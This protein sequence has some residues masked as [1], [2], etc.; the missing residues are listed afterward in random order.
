MNLHKNTIKIN[1]IGVDN[2]DYEPIDFTIIDCPKCVVGKIKK[3]E[4]SWIGKCPVCPAVYY[5]FWKPYPSQRVLK[6]LLNM[7]RTKPIWIYNIGAMN[8]GKT[9]VDMSEAVDFAMQNPGTTQGFLANDFKMLQRVIPESLD[10]FIH[11]DWLAKK[12]GV[13]RQSLTNGYIFEN[14]SKFIFMPSDDENKIKSIN[15]SRWILIEGEKIHP[16]LV[17][18]LSARLRQD[19]GVVYERDENGKY[20][21]ELVINKKGQTRIRKKIKQSFYA[22]VVEANPDAASYVF[23]DGL[24]VAKKVYHTQSVQGFKDYENLK[25]SDNDYKYAIITATPDNPYL[26]E[27]FIEEKLAT[28]TEDERRQNLYGEFVAGDT[29]VYPEFFDNVIAPYEL[30][31]DW[32][33]WV[34]LDMGVGKDPTALL[35]KTYDPYEKWYVYHI[36]KRFDKANLTE[37][38]KYL[39]EIKRKWN[40]QDIFIDPS[41]KQ[42]RQLTRNTSTLIELS[43][44][45]GMEIIPSKNAIED[46]I[47]LVAGRMRDKTIKF[48]SSCE[49][50]YAE[51]QKYRYE[52]KLGEMK[53]KPTEKFNHFMDSMRYM[54]QGTRS[55]NI[56]GIISLYEREQDLKH[57]QP[58]L[59]KAKMHHAF[60]QNVEEV[61]TND[62]G[63]IEYFDTESYEYED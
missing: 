45:V 56:H 28:W 3:P 8:T 49:E 18:A 58:S 40:L 59:I 48:F 21:T 9:D 41:S 51:A 1:K 34:S 39:K 37:V 2:Y 15:L 22:I 47:N 30:D 52:L 16:S 54:E 12:N 6:D 17:N 55:E 5:N 57:P 4:T 14:G 10:P 42:T 26:K 20:V 44:I 62:D 63:I 53:K 31:K 7:K 27:G 35:V 38:G 25:V 36:A 19:S 11:K 50:L 23:D 43:D 61:Y 46:G 24:L 13:V 32:P 29:L 60:T 33:T